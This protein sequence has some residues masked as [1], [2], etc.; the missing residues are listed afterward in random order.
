MKTYTSVINVS[1]AGNKHEAESKA[2]YINKVIEQFSQ[3]FNMEL[4]PDE[5]TQIEEE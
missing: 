5:I 2:D 1:W 3:E 4:S